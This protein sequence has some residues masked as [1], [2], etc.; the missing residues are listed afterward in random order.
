MKR[1]YIKVPREHNFYF[2]VDA[3]DLSEARIEA[4][5]AMV[6]Q[7]MHEM[8]PLDIVSVGEVKPCAMCATPHFPADLQDL[9]GKKV[10]PKCA[11]IERLG[12]PDYPV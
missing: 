11:A 4:I 1:Y 7:V 2:S 12:V 3:K 8:V 9:D 5:K 6:Y 10:C